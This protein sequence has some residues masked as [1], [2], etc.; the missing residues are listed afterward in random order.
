MTLVEFLAGV[1]A[2]YAT[3]NPV[4]FG[5]N[6]G[7]MN[8][9]VPG[10]GV[11]NVEVNGLGCFYNASF[12]FLWSVRGYVRTY[13]FDGI[14]DDLGL[15]LGDVLGLLDPALSDFSQFGC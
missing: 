4:A 12:F 9:F 8:V 15:V 14:L 3:P 10:P 13:E 2:V 11:L 5:G 6:T 1:L 7:L